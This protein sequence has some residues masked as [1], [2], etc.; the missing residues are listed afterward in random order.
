M[1]KQSPSEVIK[2]TFQKLKLLLLLL[3][4]AVLFSNL[5][6]CVIEQEVMSQHRKHAAMQ[7]CRRSRLSWFDFNNSVSDIQFRRM[8][9]MSQQCFNELCQ[10]IIAGVGENAFKSEYYIEQMLQRRVPIY[11]AHQES[12]GGFICGEVK[13]ALTLRML[14][15]G[16]YLDLA[17]IFHCCPS[18]VTAIFHKVLEEWIC[19]HFVPDLYIPNEE[20]FL[21]DEQMR[22]TSRGFAHGRSK[23]IFGGVIGALDGWLVKIAKVSVTSGVRNVAGYFSRKG[24]YAINCQVI[25]DHKKRILWRSIKSR[26]AEHDSTAFKSTN[27]YSLLSQQR[28]RLQRNGFYIIGDSAY[29]IATFLLTPFD[30][31]KPYSPEDAYNFYHSSSRIIVEC[32]FGKIDARWGIF[33]K[34]LEFDLD[35][36]I[37]VIDAAM[38]L[39][40]FIVNFRDKEKEPADMLQAE[41]D[42]FDDETVAFMRGDSVSVEDSLLVGIIN[43][44]NQ[45][46]TNDVGR[47]STEE[48][49]IRE[50]GRHIRECISVRL[51]ME[52]MSR[53][54]YLGTRKNYKTNMFG[55]VRMI[56]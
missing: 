42:M 6:K 3:Q 10:S 32:C 25:V 44:D 2:S 22:E 43:D 55:R 8:F 48:V 50:G 56:H 21:N 12:C 47:P 30:N 54:D 34:P 14:A 46:H 17:L 40:N 35:K 4:I 31:S 51:E 49:D 33:W 26:G 37:V 36:N 41:L 53:P 23:G 5:V 18:H 45:Q 11:L 28:E 20:Y 9:R 39:H 1:M 13:L 24:F 19:T 52:Q 15:G 27:L 29:G 38:R 7:R 16:S